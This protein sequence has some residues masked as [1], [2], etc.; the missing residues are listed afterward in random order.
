MHITSYY[1][2]LCVYSPPIAPGPRVRSD[3]DRGEVPADVCLP[4][5]CV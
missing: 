5:V 2:T 4:F 1:S 3:V